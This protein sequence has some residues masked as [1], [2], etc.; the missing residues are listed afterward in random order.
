MPKTLEKRLVARLVARELSQE[1]TKSVSG[2][3]WHYSS[4]F[5]GNG[6]PNDVICDDYDLIPGL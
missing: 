1:E 5:D 3:C 2:A 6:A 4:S